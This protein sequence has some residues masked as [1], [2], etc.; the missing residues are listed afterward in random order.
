M[1]LPSFQRTTH[2][3]NT[4][5]YIGAALVILFLVAIVGWTWWTAPARHVSHQQCREAMPQGSTM[6]PPTQLREIWHLETADLGQANTNPASSPPQLPTWT[7]PNPIA[8]NGAVLIADPTG[9]RALD[10]RDGA[11]LW[12]Y[13]RDIELCTALISGSA[14]YLTFNGPA[15]CGETVA[16][17]VTDG[18]YIAT[19]R[20]AHEA[21]DHPA[22]PIQSSYYPGVFSNNFAE[23]WRNDLVRVVEYGDV[24]AAVEPGMQ[25]HPNCQVINALSR[26]ENTAVI[27][28][29]DG[30][31]H[32]VFVGSKPEDSREPEVKVDIDL[33][34][35]A[36]L[37]AIGNNAATIRMG[38]DVITFDD[39]GRETS[40][41]PALS[42]L[43]IP[44]SPVAGAERFALSLNDA[45]KTAWYSA[46]LPHHIAW[47]SGSEVLFFVPET[48]EVAFT[49]PRA[50]G[51]PVSVA[52]HIAVPV[53]DGYDFYD[54]ETG[55]FKYHL[56]SARD[57]SIDFTHYPVQTAVEGQRLIEKEGSVIRSLSME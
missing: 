20:T 8:S 35:A 33:S 48:L 17:E 31:F 30:D 6:N 23:L 28:N 12:S 43:M 4:R 40:R 29:C 50:V 47:F 41:H 15:G 14:A 46:D 53:V 13:H 55:Q 5:N 45:R 11:E 18:S 38:T 44:Q 37:V 16:L 10:T 1:K 7:V 27:S 24:P 34:S 2:H 39:T 32:L 21:D 54:V 51:T 36:H 3:T 52:G 22:W 26:E 19:R 42:S 56:D 49:A 9:V 25:P 57:R